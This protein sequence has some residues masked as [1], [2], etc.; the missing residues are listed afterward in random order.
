MIDNSTSEVNDVLSPEKKVTKHWSFMQKLGFR[1][2]FIFFSLFVVPFPLYYIP[3]TNYVLKY[4]YQ[5][6]RFVNH[7]ITSSIL[8]I[9]EK[10]S[11][12]FTGSGDSLYQW[13]NIF[14]FIIIA[15]GGTLVWSL[16]DRKRPSYRV[17]SK[18]F[19]LF[20]SYYL[21]M[22]MMTYGVLKVFYLQFRFP[23]MEKLFQT[24]GHSSPMRLMWT[25]MGASKT[26]T[27]F[28]GV[29]EVVAAVLLIFRKTRLLGGVVTFGVMLNVFL[30]NMSYDIPVKLFSLQLMMMGLFIALVDYQRLLNLFVF[31]KNTI[32]ASVHQPIFKKVRSQR[33][34]FFFQ[35]ILVSYMSYITINS[36]L[37]AQKR[38]GS[39][40]PKP[41]LYGIYNVDK[42]VKNN[43]IV[44]P[45]LT[46]T[47]RWNRLLIDYPKRVSVMMM[48]DSYRRYVVKT[49]T[50]KREMTFC[51]RKDTVNKYVMKY[52]RQGKDLELSGIFKKDTFK[53]QFKHYPLKNFSLINRGFHWVNE[54]PYNRYKDK[55]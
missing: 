6:W 38:S 25:F 50:V 47:V 16:L 32:P 23:N 54:V 17:L 44:P 14:T 19:F 40:R 8:G 39:L 46:D 2:S 55:R 10:L 30:M 13:V 7:N 12:A 35:L 31:D 9:S 27:V 29:S 41:A 49:D 11:T 22:Y 51:T 18:W 34:L 42:F 20:L 3:Y 21:V 28:A 53:I 52:K 15:F 43:Q 36:R 26:Y 37:K 5:F 45:L 1:F 4:Y 24:Y 33:I 48:D